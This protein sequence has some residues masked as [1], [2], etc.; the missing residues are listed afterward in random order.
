MVEENIIV[1][2]K[3]EYPNI[4][5]I[6][7]FVL[8]SILSL[9][10]YQLYWFY[11]NWKN[12]K[13]AFAEYK[14]ISPILRT[15]G[16]FLIPIFGLYWFYK[17]FNIIQQKSRN[18]HPEL[19][20]IV[21]ILI[22]IAYICIGLLMN[23][24]S[25]YCYLGIMYFIPFVYIQKELN[26][27]WTKYETK[28]TKIK[29][30]T[31]PEFL[32]IILG[33]FI[34]ANQLH[35]ISYISPRYKNVI[36][37]VNNMNEALSS[38]KNILLDNGDVLILLEG[39]KDKP[40]EIYDYSTKT[41][42]K[43][44]K[45]AKTRS[46]YSSILLNDGQVLLTGGMNVGENGFESTV[47]SEKYNPQTQSFSLSANMIYPRANHSAVLLKNGMVLVSGG[48]DEASR[49]IIETAELYN[50]VKNKFIDSST[51]CR[52]RYKHSSILLN[53]GNVLIVGGNDSN[54]QVIKEAEIYDYKTNN[55]KCVG[56]SLNYDD[57][58]SFVTLN[59]GRVFIIGGGGEIYNPKTN[60]FNKIDN[61]YL[62]ISD[63]ML[64]KIS[65]DNILI[66]S[67][68]PLPLKIFKKEKGGIYNLKTN[69]YEDL[70]SILDGRTF[71]SA[72]QLKDKNILI[73]GGTLDDGRI[74]SSAY[75]IDKNYLLNKE[76]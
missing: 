67:N 65:N 76:K 56:E 54:N 53:N 21:S 58:Q 43:V 74:T 44:G 33:L 48:R 34:W 2:E 66:L 69:K 64:F 38:S 13:N 15:L 32:I 11:T 70:S 4:V 73:T 47:S 3:Q 68:L 12:I 39:A 20:E 25:P 30:I 22:I 6:W 51:M 24:K 7:K 10:V 29:K 62:F 71:F 41:F 63:P 14:D 5:P 37:P 23:L 61:K 28:E 75:L 1:N 42:Y 8:L 26:N 40:S 31:I 50:P 52:P 35:L 57:E 17:Q 9:G 45:N 36:T 72:V 49:K 19:I 27:V 59:D 60:T 55:F 18:I 16:A 46:W